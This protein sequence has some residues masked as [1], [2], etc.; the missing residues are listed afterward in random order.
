MSRTFKHSKRRRGNCK[1][2]PYAKR[3]RSLCGDMNTK[4]QIS[5]VYN[6]EEGRT[7]RGRTGRGARQAAKNYN[8][9]LKKSIRQKSKMEIRQA[10]LSS[11]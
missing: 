6:S 9:S 3:V 4:W 2:P 11:D 5:E 8:R 1:M 7:F 10:I